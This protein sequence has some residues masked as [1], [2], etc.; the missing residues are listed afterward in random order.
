MTYGLTASSQLASSPPG[1]LGPIDNRRRT[2]QTSSVA[3]AT[4]RF[5]LD[6]YATFVA[7]W[8]SDLAYGHKWFTITL[9]SARGNVTHYARFTS[10]YTANKKGYRF[11][12]VSCE[13]ELRERQIEEPIVIV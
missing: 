8:K 9:P 10:K 12:E 2:Q 3:P 7:W 6:Q 11:M 1:E 13:L 4:F 5:L